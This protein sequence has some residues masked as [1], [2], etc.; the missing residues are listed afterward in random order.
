MV[1]NERTSGT[2]YGLRDEYA[3][4][5]DQGEIESFTAIAPAAIE[6]SSTKENAAAALRATAREAHPN[7][8]LVL[9]PKAL[10]LDSQW[11][12]DWI[13]SLGHP[14]VLYWEG[15][16]WHRWAKPP[17]ASMRGWLERADVVFAVAREPQARLLERA[18]AG[19]VRF[20]PHTYCHVQF[21]DA[22]RADLRAGQ[23]RYDAVLV[24]S[25]LA[26]FGL[27]SRVPGATGRAS[28]V[29]RLKRSDHR[30]VVYGAGWGANGNSSSVP[31]N[32]QIDAIRESLVSVNWDHFPRHQSYVSDRLPISLLAGRVHITTA[33]QGL[34][35]L[36]GP[37]TGLFLEPSVSAVVRRV[38]ELTS[39]PVD[40]LLELGAAAHDWVRNRLSDREAAR[41]M[42]SAV[43]ESFLG[44]VPSEPWHRFV[45][46]GSR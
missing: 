42:L 34:D 1:T 28:L 39:R 21:A 26:R 45:R 19:H 8:V 10:S 4:M 35:W 3:R 44:T 16:P 23:I 37:D 31:Y 15:D 24:G 33:H 27:V 18:G 36:P 25:R 11:V 17:T 13:S 22:E 46:R 43:D 29:R 41:F 2:E 14:A 32:R 9:S 6:T 38:G 12:R 7:V 30:F 40:E 5:A 20:I